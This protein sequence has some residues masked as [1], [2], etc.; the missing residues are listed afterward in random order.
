MQYKEFMTTKKKDHKPFCR[1]GTLHTGTHDFQN[2]ETTHPNKDFLIL[3]RT[4]ELVESLTAFLILSAIPSLDWLPCLEEKV[5][6]QRLAIL[7]SDI[8]QRCA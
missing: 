3:P 2:G 5:S 4:P 1:V 6:Y 7:K 8:A